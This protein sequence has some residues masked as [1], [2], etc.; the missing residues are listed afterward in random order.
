MSGEV[1]G[2]RSCDTAAASPCSSTGESAV[3][4][5]PGWF[6][7]SSVES[8]VRGATWRD[9]RTFTRGLLEKVYVDFRRA[10]AAEEKDSGF[11]STLSGSLLVLKGSGLRSGCEGDR[12]AYLVS[13]W[14][15]GA[16]ISAMNY[17]ILNMNYLLCCGYLLIKKSVLILPML[18]T[19]VIPDD[20]Q[21]EEGHGN[22]DGEWGHIT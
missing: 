21:V 16:L 10:C 7:G 22:R 17:L 8:T 11:Q 12:A 18:Q 2:V 1:G 6:S 14:D 19:Q 20:S 3:V 13:S 4:P 5:E 9:R 15:G